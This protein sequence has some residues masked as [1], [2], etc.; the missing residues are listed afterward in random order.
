[1]SWVEVSRTEWYCAHL[2]EPSVGSKT[3]PPG[4]TGL[5]VAGAAG[6][7]GLVE[8]MSL[9][10]VEGFVG[11]VGGGA[12]NLRARAWDFSLK[13]ASF[14]TKLRPPAKIVTVWASPLS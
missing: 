10:G 2:P 5:P 14:R 6:G 3:L 8:G 11:A 7:S 9:S 4:P 12:D 13:S 1:M